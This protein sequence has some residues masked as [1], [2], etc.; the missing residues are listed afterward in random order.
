MKLAQVFQNLFE[1][2]VF[3]GE[4]QKIEIRRKDSEGTIQLL[5]INDGKSIPLELRDEIF[6]PGYTTK[7]GGGLGL[8]IV[9]KLV[10]A[11]GW[12]IHLDTSPETTFRI[13]IPN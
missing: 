12:A 5:V 7:N 3:H 1:N 9:Q 10:E 13:S 2:A 6:R 11:H 4:P 8:T